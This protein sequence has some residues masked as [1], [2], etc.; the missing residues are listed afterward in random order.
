M[1]RG[2]RSD[3]YEGVDESSIS[4]VTLVTSWETS[5][6]AFPHSTAQLHVFGALLSLEGASASRSNDRRSNCISSHKYAGT[7]SAHFHRST[8]DPHSPAETITSQ[9]CLS[10][11]AE[12]YRS[13]HT[14]LTSYAGRQGPPRSRRL[15][16]DVRTSR[17]RNALVT[18][19][20]CNSAYI[21]A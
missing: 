4:G 6:S 21:S 18:P 5:L 1:I 15:A 16:Y 11:D 3:R 8:P 13:S 9:L 17:R 10:V 2:R 14:A 7:A 12:I 20:D 19:A